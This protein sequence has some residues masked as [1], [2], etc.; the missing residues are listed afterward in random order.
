WMRNDGVG[1]LAEKALHEPDGDQREHRR[2]EGVGG[3]REGKPRLTDAAQV[4][5]DDYAETAEREQDLVGLE[6]GR[7]RSDREDARS[8]R[9]GYR[10]HVVG[11][12]RGGADEARK[13]AE[14]VLGDDVGAA[15]RLVGLHRLAIR[16][17]N[18]REQRRDR[19]RDGEDEMHRPGRGGNQHD[20][21][22]LGRIGHRRE[23]VGGED[24][25]RQ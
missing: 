7:Q 25:Q 13:S 8:D 11:Q 21:R 3:E 19:D 14:V 15:A 12:Q 2:D 17:D 1:G 24:R 4:D 16:R 20:K 10:E 22:G 23:R 9:D 5:Q 18:D 6:R